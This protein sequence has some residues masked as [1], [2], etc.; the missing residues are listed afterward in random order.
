MREK[1]CPYVRTSPVFRIIETIPIILDG[2]LI[3]R[4]PTDLYPISNTEPD[5][6]T[7][8]VQTLIVSTLAT[9]EKQKLGKDS[10][11]ILFTLGRRESKW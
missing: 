1:M 10:L 6:R 11:Y 9:F 4:I 2:S 8:W 3:S 5:V 7:T